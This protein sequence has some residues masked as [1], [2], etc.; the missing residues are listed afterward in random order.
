M[1]WFQDLVRGL[2]TA[3]APFGFGPDVSPSQGAVDPAYSNGMQFIGN[4]GM[5][6]LASGERNPM[7]AL[8]RSY[9]AAQNNA[10]EQSKQQFLAAQMLQSAEDKK[11]ERQD[12]EEQKKQFEAYV[13]TLPPDQQSLARMFP[14]KFGAAVIKQ[15]F[16]DPVGSNG[17]GLG[18]TPIPLSDGNGNWTVGQ[19]DPR[20]G[21]LVNGKPAGPGWHYDPYGLSYDKSKGSKEGGISGEAAGNYE[22]IKAKLPGLQTVITKLDDLAGKATYTL[23]GQATNAVRTQL[24]FDPSEGQVARTEYQATVANQILPLLRDTFGSQFTAR[25]GD[26]LMATLGDPD[27]TP[28]EKQVVLKAFIDQKIR[29]AQALGVQS[30]KIPAPDAAP[31]AGV[32]SADDPLGLRQ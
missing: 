29:D 30:G 3:N 15:K 32:P 13:S 21:V 25:E 23:A 19:L 24:G 26:T 27:K 22:S 16:P 31:Q 4:L 28:Q 9:L 5:G 7:T 2:G 6:I 14:D 17:G 10:Q 8:G 12:A 11:K 1:A 20:G 18:M